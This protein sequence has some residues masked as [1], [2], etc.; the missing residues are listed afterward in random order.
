MRYLKLEIRRR[1]RGRV[2]GVH[3][4]RKPNNIFIGRRAQTTELKAIS[5]LS[6]PEANVANS[7]PAEPFF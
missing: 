5:T 4:S 6:N 3:P 1:F 2:L 7:L